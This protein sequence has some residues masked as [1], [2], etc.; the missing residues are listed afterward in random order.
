MPRKRAD[1]RSEVVEQIRANIARKEQEKASLLR[2][3]EQCDQ[4]LSALQGALHVVLRMAWGQPEGKAQPA[5]SAQP[6]PG[7]EDATESMQAAIRRVALAQEGRY[8]PRS[9]ADIIHRE[10]P[11]VA[12]RM[13]KNY[14]ASTLWKMAHRRS[15]KIIIVKSDGIGTSNEYENPKV[16]QASAAA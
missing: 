1:S 14:V 3:T 4:E 5:E 2:K 10:Y 6:S 11:Q 9:I 7:R 8:T 16:G 15:P 12:A 13:P